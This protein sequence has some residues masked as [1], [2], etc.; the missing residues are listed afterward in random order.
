MKLSTHISANSHGT[1][2]LFY[3]GFFCQGFFSLLAEALDLGLGDLL[4]LVQLLGEH[5]LLRDATH[6]N[7]LPLRAINAPPPA[8]RPQAH[9]ATSFRGTWGATGGCSV[10]EQPVRS[11]CDALPLAAALLRSP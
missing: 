8:H 7:W 2:N 11:P 9:A 6:G 5:L 1:S 3:V 10:P 4:A